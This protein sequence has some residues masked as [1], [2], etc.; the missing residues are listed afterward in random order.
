MKRPVLWHS[1]LALLHAVVCATPVLAIDAITL[2]GGIADSDE[3]V[4]RFGAMVRWDLQR[5][6]LQTGDWRLGSYVEFSV[7]YWDGDK[8][9]TGNDDLFDFG[10]TPVLRWEMEPNEGLAPF[11][12]LGV[13]THLHTQTRIGDKDFDIPLAFGNHFGAGARFGGGRYEVLYRFQHLSN[14]SLGDDNPGLN[15]HTVLVSYHF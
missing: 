2:E 14:A 13:G 15:F 1:A 7:A 5:K 11:V 9:R 3:D 6:W 8:G 4:N 12:E 10:L